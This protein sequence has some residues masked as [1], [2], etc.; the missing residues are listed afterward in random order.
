MP[1]FSLK[2]A[3]ASSSLANVAPSAPPHAMLDVAYSVR[4]TDSELE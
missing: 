4:V 1:P 2:Y 3:S